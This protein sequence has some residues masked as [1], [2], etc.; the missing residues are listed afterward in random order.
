MNARQRATFEADLAR[1]VRRA[2]RIRAAMNGSMDVVAVE[3]KE[4]RLIK[5]HKRGAHTR[6]IIVRRK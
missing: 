6:Y 1:I 4:S 3:V 2:N 5:E